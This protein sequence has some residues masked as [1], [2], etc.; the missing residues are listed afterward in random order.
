[1]ALHEGAI[2]ACN[3]RGQCQELDDPCRVLHIGA[4][5]EFQD[6]GTWNSVPATREVNFATAFPF[7]VQ[8]PAFDVKPIFT[9]EDIEL[10]RCPEPQLRKA[11]IE[12]DAQPAKGKVQKTQK[13]RKTRQAYS[14]PRRKLYPK[15]SNP[16]PGFS[17][18]IGIG[19]GGGGGGHGG[20]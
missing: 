19:G 13:T 20:H 2:R 1:L 10:G 17:I 9:R 11:K 6:P 8:P 12:D 15:Y 5:G 14:R 4:G 7:V 18:S 16:N 3:E